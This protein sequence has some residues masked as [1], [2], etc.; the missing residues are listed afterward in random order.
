MIASQ[1]QPCLPG[2][3][4]QLLTE[5]INWATQGDVETEKKNVLWLHGM[6]GSGK[7]TVATTIARHFATL[8]RRGAYLFFERATSK[9]NSAIRTLAYNLAR[10]DGGLHS[11]ISEAINANQSIASQPL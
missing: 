11:A 1:R 7:S 5:I 9:P 3:R 10:F 2:T 6:A 8:G 4:K